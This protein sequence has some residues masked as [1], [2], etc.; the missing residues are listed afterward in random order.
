MPIVRLLVLLVLAL[1]SFGAAAQCS[2]P[3]CQ[4]LKKIARFN[5]DEHSRYGSLVFTTP[6]KK[7]WGLRRAQL[8]TVDERD[9]L[10][11]RDTLRFVRPSQPN[12]RLRIPVY[13]ERKGDGSQS[14]LSVGV[15]GKHRG[16]GV[17]WEKKF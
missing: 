17:L 14:K 3:E 6:Q 8:E 9:D 12:L 5:G 13:E 11:V 2:L 1:G 7:A 4:P 16:V 10:W 15:I